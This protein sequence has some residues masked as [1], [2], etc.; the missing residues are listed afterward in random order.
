M[1]KCIEVYALVEGPTEQLFV[2][3]ILAPY[4]AEK[5]VFMT[6]MI[7]SKPGQKGGDVRFCRAQNDIEILLL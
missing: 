6:P 4:L 1:N 7:I 5:N 2:R 3:E